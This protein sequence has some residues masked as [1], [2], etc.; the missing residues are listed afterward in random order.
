MYT[1]SSGLFGREIDISYCTP[2]P[3]PLPVSTLSHF[4]PCLSISVK[5]YI[6]FRYLEEDPMKPT[7]YY[8][9]TRNVVGVHVYIRIFNQN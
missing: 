3:S 4:F 5:N 6:S 2:P 1:L 8:Y 9:R 7:A